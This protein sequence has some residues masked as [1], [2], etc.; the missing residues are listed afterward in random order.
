MPSFTFPNG[1]T[2]PDIPSNISEKDFSALEQWAMSKGGGP[3]A[4]GS[5]SVIVPGKTVYGLEQTGLTMED[6]KQVG[7]AALN[8]PTFGWGT[9]AIN[10][11]QSMI[12]G[13]PSYSEL[14]AQDSLA[15]SE[16]AKTHPGVQ[17]AVGLLA[18][19]PVGGLGTKA[20][21]KYLPGAVKGIE[22]GN[23]AGNLSKLG[24]GATAL[25]NT[26]E[27]ALFGS[28]YAPQGKAVEGASIG[29]VLGAGA[30]LAHPIYNLGEQS[31]G[32]A[33]GKISGGAK[34]MISA[35][36][37]RSAI[38]SAQKAAELANRSD[39][40]GRKLLTDI[41][42]SSSI[43]PAAADT[44]LSSY[45]PPGVIVADVAN[46]GGEL[47]GKT[48]TVPGARTFVEAL[49][50]SGR[51]SSQKVL[52]AAN[53]AA[54]LPKSPVA[55]TIAN[56]AGV[57]LTTAEN[58][59]KMLR[60]DLGVKAS[61]EFGAVRDQVVSPETFAQLKAEL[62]NPAFA[63]LKKHL[64]DQAAYGKDK[65]LAAAVRNLFPGSP[66]ITITPT[67]KSPGVLELLGG[68]SSAKAGS[69]PPAKESVL[70]VG[71]FDTLRKQINDFA[72]SHTN[73]FGVLNKTGATI[74]QFG[75]GLTKIVGAEHP[76]YTEAIG[77]YSGRRA[78]MDYAGQGSRFT[79][80][81][82][83]EIRDILS[84]ATDSERKAYENMAIHDIAMVSGKAK[85]G[86]T[87]S[88][89]F[90]TVPNMEQK[91]KE[92]F[93]YR[94]DAILQAV[95]EAKAGAVINTISQGGASSLQRGLDRPDNMAILLKA[96]TATRMGAVKEVAN[97]FGQM[98]ATEAAAKAGLSSADA[99]LAS[100]IKSNKSGLLD[101]LGGIVHNPKGEALNAG[102]EAAISSLK[103]YPPETIT[104]VAEIL[105]SSP[106]EQM[107]ISE[108][109]KS[110]MA[111]KEAER[112]ARLSR[113]GRAS[114]VSGGL[115]ASLSGAAGGSL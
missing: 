114:L 110:G 101:K 64:S 27:G 34:D 53:I 105:T 63:P 100:G 13:Q 106:T 14:Q 21:V 102:L 71:Q 6:V 77:N 38:R 95:N 75:S 32:W 15:E 23:A 46:I 112:L 107:T 45:M 108:L 47:L 36:T 59:P 19:I 88:V 29:S 16:Y 96:V 51:S 54:N 55:E 12:L 67:A 31:A 30:T 60:Q 41:L 35:L 113:T 18:S 74:K 62:N 65:E 49:A 20:V 69:I 111:V 17:G 91:I 44:A 33:G 109:M 84:N 40:Q 80:S 70:T 61:E 37:G 98:A 26:A 92:A 76:A 81:T 97:R 25:A 42:A 72:A 99:A 73:D 52:E 58:L 39:T 83:A 68:K 82:P 104:R 2:V 78:V 10:R 43:N 3:I 57:N 9:S 8:G 93:G 1:V 22:A 28:G 4:A 48:A 85:E 87:G 50:N 94:A 24:L 7:K 86:S 89:N 66:R 90:L 11:G 115:A 79:K 5:S 56:A 103:G